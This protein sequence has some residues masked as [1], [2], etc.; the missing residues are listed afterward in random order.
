MGIG[1]SK[2]RR[3]TTDP[4]LAEHRW[5]NDRAKKSRVARDICGSRQPCDSADE[6]SCSSSRENASNVC[7]CLCKVILMYVGVS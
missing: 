6:E 3:E 7:V 1:W 4:E 2:D 5:D